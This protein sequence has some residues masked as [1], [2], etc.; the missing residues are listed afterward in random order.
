MERLG[1]I[2]VGTGF[3]HRHFVLPAFTRGQHQDWQL[4]LVG[5]PAADQAQAV[6]TRQAEIDNGDVRRMLLQEIIGFLGILC[7]INLMAHFTHLDGEV[8]A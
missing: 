5:A 6:F 4:H 1:H 2:V 3:Q 8:V 7:R